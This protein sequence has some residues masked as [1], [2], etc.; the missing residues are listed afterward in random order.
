[1]ITSIY[2]G[3]GIGNQLIYTTNLLATAYENNIN[4]KNI[5]FKAER[6]FKVDLKKLIVKMNGQGERL[7][8]FR[9]MLIYV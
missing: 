7:F 2:S 6:Y 9:N 1:M 8:F 3:G 4:F 5:A